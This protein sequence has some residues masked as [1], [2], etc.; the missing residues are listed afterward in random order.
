MTGI[1]V[2][3][4]ADLVWLCI[5]QLA[6]GVTITLAELAFNMVDL[7]SRGETASDQELV[8]NASALIERV[9]PALVEDGH[10]TLTGNTIRRLQTA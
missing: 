7:L 4:P 1:E 6:A 9:L 3:S 5:V 8:A 10:I 2:H